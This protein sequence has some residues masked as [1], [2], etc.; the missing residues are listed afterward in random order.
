MLIALVGKPNAG[1]TTLFNALTMGKAQVAD[2]PFTTIDPNKGVAFATVNCPCAELHTK[3][4]PR[5]GKCENGVRQVPV[6]VVDVAG[7]VEGASEGKGM[8]NQ[9]LSDA[10]QADALVLVVDA[11]GSSDLEG[12]KVPEGSGNPVEEAEMILSEIEKWLVQVIARNAHKAKGKSFSEFAQLLSGIRVSEDQIRQAVLESGLGEGFSSWNSDELQKISRQLLKKTKPVAIAA[13]KSDSKFAFENAGKLRLAF[14]D[15][16]V[17]ETCGD[18]ELAFERALEKGFFEKSDGKVK[19]KEGVDPKLHSAL[20]RI[21]EIREKG[22]GVQ[23]LLNSVVFDLLKIIVAFPV[24]DEAHFK[25]NKGSV[26]PDAILLPKNS[27]PIHLAERIHSDFAKHFL[28]AID[29]RKKMRLGRDH[30]L[31][32]GSVVRIVSAK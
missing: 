31:E 17:I 2:Y 12:R 6:N 24:E 1:K 32:N 18:A 14:P 8:G 28:Y 26:L 5:V 27:T 11:S 4:N 21:L 3:C 7:L 16:P 10:A 13:N 25:D 29:A 20:S 15:F 30:A 22:T 23:K 9:F 19:I